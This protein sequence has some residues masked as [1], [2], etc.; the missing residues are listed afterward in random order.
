MPLCGYCNINEVMHEGEVCPTCRQ[1]YNLPQYCQGEEAGKSQGSSTPTSH[2]ISSQYPYPASIPS[3][4][5]N[6]PFESQE[7][8]VGQIN[9]VLM[10]W[11]NDTSV[12]DTP[13]Y[14][15]RKIMIRGRRTHD[16]SIPTDPYGN[17]I[18]QIPEE[19][20]NPATTGGVSSE[21]VS[22][23]ADQAV[24]VIN[25][26]KAVQQKKQ[27]ATTTWVT[28]GIAKNIVEDVDE[29]RGF[30]IKYLRSLFLGY[31]FCFVDN[32][33]SFQ[34]FP[35]YTGQATTNS[36]NACDQIIMYGKI[37]RGLINENN[38]VEIYGKRASDGTIGV[39]YVKNLASG[40]RVTPKGVIPAAV[41][42]LIT[43]VIVALFILIFMGI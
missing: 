1:M 43:G 10:P 29:K 30:F 15:T 31:P 28:K 18:V 13:R 40:T 23:A 37:N 32:L 4:S 20:Y 22:A 21:E 27:Q 24:N 14:S 7:K 36:G 9:P 42:R 2:T 12:S 38:E 25:N 39:D 8:S 11:R 26:Q 3:S 16:V 6:V 34:V 5:R 33:I 35:D 41:I 19:Q 17:P